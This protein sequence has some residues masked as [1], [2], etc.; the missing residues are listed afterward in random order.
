MTRSA[1][2]YFNGV[3]AGELTEQPEGYSFC[4]LDNYLAGGT[5]ISF[6][7]PLQEQAFFS[8]EFPAFFENLVSE[9]WMKKIQSTEQKIDEN[10]PFGLLL[11]NG[12]DLVGAV[13]LSPKKEVP[14]K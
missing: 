10:D 9:G 2:V 1:I 3:A 11:E 5:P 13:T 4:Y 12:G 14:N 7:F 6:N 8:K